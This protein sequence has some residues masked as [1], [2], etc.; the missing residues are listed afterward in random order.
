[1]LG[2]LTFGGSVYPAHG[3]VDSASYPEVSVMTDSF[4]PW[5]QLVLKL[6]RLRKNLIS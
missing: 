6:T 2:V 3:S 5:S 4:R 1:V